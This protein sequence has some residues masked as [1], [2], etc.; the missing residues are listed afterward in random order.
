MTTRMME[1]EAK[2]FWSLARKIA[3]IRQTPDAPL[4]LADAL[5]VHLEDI[6]AIALHSDWPRLR[7]SAQTVL[8]RGWSRQAVL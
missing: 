8:E 6:E 2:L 4:V 5:V 1:T 7:K 3:A